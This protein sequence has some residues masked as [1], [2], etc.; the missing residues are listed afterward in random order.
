[1]TIPA[2]LSDFVTYVTKHLPLIITI[3]LESKL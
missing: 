1:M 2:Y 3:R